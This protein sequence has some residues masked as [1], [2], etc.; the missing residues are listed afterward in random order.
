MRDSVER[1]RGPDG[2]QV[3]GS[4]AAG[5]E[6][7]YR[8]NALK[9]DLEAISGNTGRV[10]QLLDPGTQLFAAVKAN[11]YGFGLPRVAEAMLAGGADAFSMADPADALRIRSA[12]IDVPLLLYGGVLPERAMGRLLAHHDLTCTVADLE[13]ARAWSDLACGVKAF[14]KIDVGLERLGVPAEQAAEFAVAACSLQGIR[15]EGIYTHLHG[16]ETPG[17][18]AW[19]LDRFDLALDALASEGIA[20]PICMAESS[21]TIG[22]ERRPRLN[23]VDPGH[24]LYGFRPVGRSGTPAGIRPAFA[25]LTTRVIH[26]KEVSRAAFSETA[27]V[28]LREG[29]RIA[30][31]PFGRADGIRLLACG[32]V[33]V[34]ERRVPIVGRPSLEH[35][36]LDVT[37]VPDCRAGDEVVV[38]GRQ[39]AEEISFDEVAAQHGL[40]GVGLVLE[41]RPTVRRIYETNPA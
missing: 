9:V 25:S 1:V 6:A 5:V 3:S 28:P 33:L 19:Q 24:I 21:V 16:G 40:D 35:T 15:V 10:R 11:A 20:L 4:A 37:D 7:A 26:V 34:R 41:A 22:L 27:P 13:A 31:I 39:G 18:A 29:M 36:R 14:L 12:G 17:Y 30:V 32:D 38:I 23:A 2:A 8:P